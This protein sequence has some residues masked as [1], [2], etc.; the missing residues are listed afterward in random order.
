M[1]KALVLLLILLLST[2]C[3]A[4]IESDSLKIF[5]VTD[6]G[7]AMTSSLTLTIK[8]GSGMIWTDIE[9]LVGTST[10]STAKI[11]VETAHDYS[12]EVERYD[13]FFNIESDASLVE[14][15]SAGAAMTLLVISMLQDKE[16]PDEVALTGTITAEGGIGSVCGICEK[17]KEADKVG[18]TFFMI[19]PGDSRQ[20]VK[21][22][23]EVKSINL[24]DYAHKNWGIKIIEVNN[25]DDVLFYAFTEIDSI[26]INTGGI[27]RIDFIP[28]KINLSENL[29]PMKTLTEKYFSDAEDSVR[30]A[31]TALSGTMLN[32]S[33]L[34]D[35]MLSYLNESEKTLDKG[36]IL[37]GQNFLYSAAN[38]YFLA[39]IN[40]N[41]VKDI[42]ENPNLLSRNSTAFNNKVK[43]LSGEIDSLAY[44]LNKFIPIEGFEW[45]IA[46]K[47]RLSWAKLK[48]DQLELSDDIVIIVEQDGLDL[49]R[50]SDIMDYEYA[51]AWYSVSKDF[52]ELTKET[53]TGILPDKGLSNLA[54]SY[55]A[56]AENALEALGDVEAED[57][58]RRLDSAKM[59][60]EEGWLYATLFDSSSALA[61][62]NSEIFS[63]DKT[64]TQLQTALI[65]RLVNLDQK[66][67]ENENE[68]IWA[69]L[70]LDHAKYYLDSSEFYSMQEQ[71]ALALESAKSGLDLVF[72]AEGV[73][74]AASISYDHI[75]QLPQDSFIKISPGWQDKPELEDS[76]YV[77]VL[78]LIFAIVLIIFSVVA[79]EK[80]FHLL[81]KF[82]FEDRLDDI[83]KQQ[84]K[85]RQ[86][87]EKGYIKKEQF[88]VLNKPI[89]NKLNALL[90]ERRVISANY[91]DL[92]LNKSKIDAFENVLKD[93]RIQLRKRKITAEDYASNTAFY[94]KRVELLKQ[95]VKEDEQKIKSGKKKAEV[96]FSKENTKIKNETKKAESED[97]QVKIEKIKNKR[98]K[99]KK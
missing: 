31:K 88:E 57:I 45:H 36:K 22:N 51:L 68:F 38:Y 43:K 48:L 89:Q 37:Y 54:D 3:F 82:S 7:N 92:D 10:Q 33:A 40:S 42:S 93:L 73:F 35:A 39:T 86:R 70:Y 4:V 62:A 19:P 77:F 52:F 90:A 66:I 41:F 26:D 32:D 55:I 24:I 34:V 49:E 53:T 71:P 30:L 78:L 18:I 56:N 75:S 23:G 60:R 21:E 76:L 98:K 74:D 8:P 12:N 64:L 5:A 25:I 72:L 27:L 61:L 83:L 80:K 81:K 85:L 97:K 9:P 46:A 14:G 15:P 16:I 13:Y 59:L 47:E 91:V 28:D 94:T 96:N 50:I 20:T 1:K 2:G 95:I 29:N 63:K 67:N 65:E 99:R 84:R 79:S 58:K 17:S 69:R 6:Q 87:L 11:A 44:D